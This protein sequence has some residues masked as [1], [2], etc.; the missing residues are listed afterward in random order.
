MAIQLKDLLASFRRHLR[1]AARAVVAGC[2]VHSGGAADG[3]ALQTRRVHGVTKE[4]QYGQRGYV[5]AIR[6]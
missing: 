4:T 3:D 6:N 2:I 5:L 1:A